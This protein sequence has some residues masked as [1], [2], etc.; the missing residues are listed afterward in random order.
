MATDLKISSDSKDFKADG[1]CLCGSVKY[2]LGGEPVYRVACHC[3][4]CRRGTGTS[5]VT[6]TIFYKKA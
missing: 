3:T 4:N 6:N 5:F 1:Q 2:M